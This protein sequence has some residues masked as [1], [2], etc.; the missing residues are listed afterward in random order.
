MFEQLFTYHR[1]LLRHLDGPLVAERRRFLESR[2]LQGTPRS[3]LL[4]Y[5][6]EMRIVASLLDLSGDRRIAAQE[7]HAAARRWGQ[8][9]RRRGRALGGGEGSARLFVQTATAWL[10][11]LGRLATST[12]PPLHFAA[13]WEEWA[14]FL[15]QSEGLRTA[16]VANYGWWI[17]KFLTWLDDRPTPLIRVQIASVDSF[18]QDLASQG[19]SRVSLATAAKALRRFFRF[20]W[21]R[22]WCRRNLAPAILSPRLYRYEDLPAGPAWA[23]VLRLITSTGGGELR[24]LRSHAMLRLLAIYGLRSGEVRGLLLEDID[25]RRNLLRVRRGKSTRVQIYPITRATRQALRRY[26]EARPNSERPEF[27]LSLQA[28]FRPLSAGA[29]YHVIQALFER[30]DVQSSKRGAHA[31]RHACATHLLAEGLSLKEI[32]DHLGHRNAESTRLYAK[33]DGVALRAVA[34]WDLGGVI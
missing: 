28:P 24:D 10:G 33:V 32:G 12:P 18:L 8:Q 14:A 3:T 5:A 26:R 21:Q 25:W 15:R 4:R 11:F 1:V 17:R 30:W 22:G 31:L 20:A 34:D 7:I 29:L 16:T 9:Q 19:L 27:F 23:D 6:R 2:A 13:Q